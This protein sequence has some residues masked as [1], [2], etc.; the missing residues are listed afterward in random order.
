MSYINTCLNIWYFGFILI[1]AGKYYSDKYT[2]GQIVHKIIFKKKNN[3][4]VNF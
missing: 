4:T 2:M 3:R 1:G